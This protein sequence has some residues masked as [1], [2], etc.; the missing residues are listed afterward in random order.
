MFVFLLRVFWGFGLGFVF[1]F[2]FGSG[3]FLDHRYRWEKKLTITNRRF[4]REIRPTQ[5]ETCFDW[6]RGEGSGCLD[7]DLN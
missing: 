1:V 2:W 5:T 6:K 4:H 3:F 7:Q